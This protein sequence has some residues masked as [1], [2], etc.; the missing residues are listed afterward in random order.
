MLW[1]LA[2][3]PRPLAHVGRRA[4]GGADGC[5]PG[6]AARRRQAGAHRRG[7][8]AVVEDACAGLGTVRRGLAQQVGRRTAGCGGDALLVEL[9]EGGRAE[10]CA[11]LLGQSVSGSVTDLVRAVATARDPA[12]R[13]TFDRHR[14]RT[15]GGSGSAHGARAQWVQPGVLL[16]V[17]GHQGRRSVSED[18]G[19]RQ[20]RGVDRRREWIAPVHRS[21]DDRARR[22]DAATGVQ[23]DRRIDPLHPAPYVGRREDRR[24]LHASPERHRRRNGH[25]AALEGR[26]HGPDAERLPHG[27]QHALRSTGP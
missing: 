12:R 22:P 11:D 8:A 15:P 10:P 26:C 6:R 7:R 5:R 1:E 23:A 3:S 20:D 4:L 17:A 14:G 24:A 18:D 13:R 9:S 19:G 27:A 25:G 2:T 21:R 16:H